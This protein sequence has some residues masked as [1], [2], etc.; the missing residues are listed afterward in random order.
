ML[1]IYFKNDEPKT[2]GAQVR[3]LLDQVQDSSLQAT[4]AG[5]NI[6]V[7]KDPDYQIWDFNKCA[8]HIAS[9]I[10]KVNPGDTKTISGVQAKPG[11]GSRN[12]IYKDGEIFTGTYSAQEWKN[13]SKDEQSSVINAR[14]GKKGTG[15]KGPVAKH[16]KK[17]KALTKKVKKQQKQIASLKKRAPTSDSDDDEASSGD[18]TSDA[19]N[20]FGGRAG[21]AKKKKQKNE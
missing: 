3:W 12:G 8:N 16:E 6:D 17:V 15:G 5:L 11:S 4:I 13:L 18:P 10:R 2:M 1:N 19:G 14:G 9:Q 7:E 21:K 20:A